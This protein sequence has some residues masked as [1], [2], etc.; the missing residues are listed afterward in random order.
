M[1]TQL[2]IQ[3]A[4]DVESNA[5]WLRIEPGQGATPVATG[6]LE[7]LASQTTGAQIIV[8]VSGVDV[9]LA[10]VSVPTANKQRML[11]AIPFALEDQVA[12]SVEDMHF[13]VGARDGEGKVETAMVSRDCMDAWIQRL[14]DAGIYPH[15]IIPDF[16]TLPMSEDHWNLLTDG[17]LLYVACGSDHKVCLDLDNAL[18][19]LELLLDEQVKEAEQTLFF[20]GDESQ[21]QSLNPQREN[22]SF[23]IVPHEGGLLEFLAQQPE[24]IPLDKTINLLQGD[25]SRREQIGKIWRPWRFAASLAGV[26]FVLQLGISIFDVSHLEG[27][28]ELLDQQIEKVYRSA[29]PQARKIVNPKVQM[30]RELDKLR[31]GESG[32]QAGFLSLLADIS[33]AFQQTTGLV[34]RSVR[35]KNSSLDVEL[36]VSNLQVLDQLKQKLAKDAQ[37][38]VEI[39]SAAAK[40]NIVQGRLSIKRST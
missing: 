5:R 35:Y 23:E 27:E 11:K 17:D 34:L 28:K 38:A 30:Q 20:Y 25:Y 32:T 26:W 21:G 10:K 22:I 9:S 39:Q 8:L 18:F 40:D 36:E 31:G 19:M 3:L 13:A 1:R 37:L 15:A 14:S 6:S 7:D 12:E 4:K 29:F 2:I 16:L 24:G 33:G